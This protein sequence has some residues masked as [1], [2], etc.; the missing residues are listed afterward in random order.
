MAAGSRIPGFYQRSTDERRRELA[1]RCSLSADEVAA[2]EGGLS[3]EIADRMIENVI[4]TYALPFAVGLNMTLNG[5]D[6]LVTMVVEE[7]SVVAAMSNACRMNREGGGFTAEADAPITTAQV[8]LWDV[9]DG[10]AASAAVTA[11]AAAANRFPTSS[12]SRWRAIESFDRGEGLFVVHLHVDARRHGRE[13][14]EHHGGGDRS[15][16]CRSG[17]RAGRASHSH[18]FG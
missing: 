18:Q 2:L 15:S 10:K 7:P 4:G 3:T 13:H 14:G 6:Y 5:K 1:S 16:D 17:Q 8:Q 9:A 12:A 11:H